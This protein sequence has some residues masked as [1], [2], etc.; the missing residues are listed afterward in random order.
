MFRVVVQGRA[1]VIETSQ[2]EVLKAMH[3]GLEELDLYDVQ[4]PNNWFF[5]LAAMVHRAPNL[6]KLIFGGS[7]M[8]RESYPMLVKLM[9]ANFNIS[10][11]EFWYPPREYDFI[12]NLVRNNETNLT[13]LR[14]ERSWH[15]IDKALELL[16]ALKY[17]THLTFL[18]INFSCSTAPSLSPKM[19]EALDYNYTLTRFEGT[20]FFYGYKKRIQDKLNRNRFH[21]R[22]LFDRLFQARNL[23]KIVQPNKRT[24]DQDLSIKKLKI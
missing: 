13:H 24:P 21:S 5:N 22:T 14:V 7:E 8:P 9:N 12:I 4:E 3:D 16:E 15:N 10:S 23:R 2:C 11:L 18:S 1:G 17:N 19:S 20:P 6:K